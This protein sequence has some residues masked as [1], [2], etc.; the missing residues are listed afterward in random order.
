M[1]TPPERVSLG[2]P[3]LGLGMLVLLTSMLLRIA[4]LSRVDSAFMLLCGLPQDW[5]AS[6]I[7]TLLMWLVPVRAMRELATAAALFHLVIDFGLQMMAGAARL[8]GERI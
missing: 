5:K 4:L 6:A 3:P 1:L 7:F 2:S 8:H